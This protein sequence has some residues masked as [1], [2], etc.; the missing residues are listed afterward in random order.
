[1]EMITRHFAVFVP[2]GR[3]INPVT[4]TNWEGVGVVPE[5]KVP[6]DSALDAALARAK[7]RM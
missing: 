6:A 4:G 2:A 7:K 3:A 1:M 5:I